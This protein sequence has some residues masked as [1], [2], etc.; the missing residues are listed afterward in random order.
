MLPRIRLRLL[1][2][3]ATGPLLDPALDRGNLLGPQRQLGVRRHPLA[4]VSVC[5][6]GD[7]ETSRQV[8]GLNNRPAIAPLLH[9]GERIQSQVGLL[10]ESRMAGEAAALQ[11]RLDVLGVID[12]LRGQ[13]G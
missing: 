8:P 4:R 13:G 2:F 3:D 1:V 12:R 6:A 11:D 5:D 9:A 10:F 7:E